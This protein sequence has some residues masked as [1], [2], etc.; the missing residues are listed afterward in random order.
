ML[1]DDYLSKVAHWVL[2]AKRG[3]GPST[4]QDRLTR[5]FSQTQKNNTMSTQFI[6][7]W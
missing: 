1:P 2:G 3:K 5:V 6:F 7:P 4:I